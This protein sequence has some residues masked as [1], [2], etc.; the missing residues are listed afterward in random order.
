MSSHMGTTSP[1]ETKITYYMMLHWGL[2]P[3]VTMEVV[4][5]GID[6]IKTSRKG[7]HTSPMGVQQDTMIIYIKIYS[8][9]TNTSI[10]PLN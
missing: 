8:E 5:Q 9:V 3:Q 2:F 7:V 1:R 6:M 10:L 4:P